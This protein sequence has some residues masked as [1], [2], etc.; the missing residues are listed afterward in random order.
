[1]DMDALP[2]VSPRLAA[3]ERPPD[4][5]VSGQ[6]ILPG[7]SIPQGRDVEQI[8]RAVD[9]AHRVDSLAGRLDRIFSERELVQLPDTLPAA[10]A[11]RVEEL[12]GFGEVHRADDQVVVPAPEIVVDV[13]SVEQAA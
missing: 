11:E 6:G 7:L 13:D 8:E 12:Q 9:T 10:L 5:S 1:M 4:D 3:Q 2:P